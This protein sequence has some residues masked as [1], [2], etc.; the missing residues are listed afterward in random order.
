[1]LFRSGASFAAYCAR[2]GIT[3]RVFIPE[4]A[5]GPKRKQIEAYG[6][7]MVLVPGQRQA[8]AEA[9]LLEVESGAVYA[10]H[11]WMPFGLTG[12]ATIAYEIVEE[13]GRAPASIIVP[14]GHGGLIY[15][16]MRGFRAMK[17]AGAIENEPE[18]VGVQSAAC[19]PIFHAYQNGTLQV[20]FLDFGNTVAEGVKV[21]R[22]VRA[23][24]ILNSLH[25][26]KG[27]M[28]SIREEILLQAWQ[29][30]ASKGI[31]I[32]PTSALVWA[33]ILEK[34]KDFKTPI[35]AV[36]SGSGYKSNI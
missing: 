32:E 35:V 22:P 12:I 6:A 24:A 7:D 25:Q 34:G 9:V 13:L 26:G 33:A 2:A 4:S 16:L 14:V 17:I 21:T 18:Y 30:A 10:S 1:M 23:S 29:A 28:L 20:N 5:S 15:G 36:I 27:R 31:H 11:A 8:A 19:A 3:A